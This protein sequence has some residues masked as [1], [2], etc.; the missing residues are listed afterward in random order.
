RFAAISSCPA[1]AGRRSNC[2]AID[3]IGIGLRKVGGGAMPQTIGVQQ[4]DGREGATDLSLHESAQAIKDFRERIPSG[5][6]LEDPSL[7][8]EEGFPA[9]ALRYQHSAPLRDGSRFY[10]AAPRCGSI[11]AKFPVR[12]PHPYFAFDRSPILQ[13]SRHSATAL[14]RSSG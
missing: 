14:D 3:R 13:C 6:H 8:D 1:G 12:A 5:H 9:W 7:H 4:R 2:S 11:T 10:P